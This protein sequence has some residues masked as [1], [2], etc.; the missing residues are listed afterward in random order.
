M[1]WYAPKRCL[2]SSET[3][4]L[5]QHDLLLFFFLFTVTVTKMALEAAMMIVR[6]DVGFVTWV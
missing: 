5:T 6:L 1:A 4:V 2:R 3:H